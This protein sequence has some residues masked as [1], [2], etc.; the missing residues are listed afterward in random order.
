MNPKWEVNFAILEAPSQASLL[1]H[2]PYDCE[3]DSSRQVLSPILI[4]LHELVKPQLIWH[5]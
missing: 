3:N 2:S 5:D 1:R 4:S